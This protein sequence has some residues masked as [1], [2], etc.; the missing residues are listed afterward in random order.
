MAQEGDHS[1]G[2]R[3]VKHAAKWKDP[4]R[5]E[6]RLSVFLGP[7]AGQCSRMGGSTVEC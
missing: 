3:L 6:V 4:G 5:A 7:P 1:G 2:Q